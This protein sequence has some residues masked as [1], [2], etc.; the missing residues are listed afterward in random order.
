MRRLLLV[1]ILMFAL[2]SFA[3]ADETGGADWYSPNGHADGLA[4][5]LNSQDC[6]DHTHDY[7]KYEP[8]DK[9]GIGVDLNIWKSDDTDWY[10]P[11]LLTIEER[12]DFNE[13]VN[14]VYAV[15]T[16]NIFDLFNK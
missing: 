10:K 12:Y 9:Y 2:G 1:A 8:E 3:I 5:F 15:V 4:K 6:L 13:N 14:S 16:F 11:N 7:E